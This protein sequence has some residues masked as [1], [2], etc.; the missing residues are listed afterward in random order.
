MYTAS[1][2][3]YDDMSDALS[4]GEKGGIRTISVRASAEQERKYREFAASRGITVSEF[5]RQ[6]ADAAIAQAEEILRQA[7]EERRH[8]E[9]VA[10]F[11]RRFAAYKQ[12][13]VDLGVRQYS[14]EEI[15]AM[16]LEQYA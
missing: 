3:L 9:E 10:D 4:D 7:D 13:L 12:S 11:M 14:D 2:H 16:R 15:E 1:Y 6:S 8:A 5:L